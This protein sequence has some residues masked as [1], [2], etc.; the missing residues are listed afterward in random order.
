M[1]IH[2]VAAMTHDRVIGNNG[3][4]AWRLP[5]DLQHFK[6]VTLNKTIVMGRKT[7]VSIGK[8]LPAR[9]NIVLTHDTQWHA[10]EVETMHSIADVLA[11]STTDI[12]I[13]IIGGETL[14]QQFLPYTSSIYL[15]IVDGQIPGD[16]HFPMLNPSDWRVSAE[17][18]FPVDVDH[19]YAAAFFHYTRL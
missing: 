16:T 1:T 6:R 15:T 9:R 19:P 2:L 10:P 5:K 14:Y 12:D 3:Q 11:L 13:M 17:G 8:A 4:L 18:G 7:F